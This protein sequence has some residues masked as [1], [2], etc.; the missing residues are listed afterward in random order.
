[1][2]QQQL[3]NKFTYPMWGVGYRMNQENMMIMQRRRNWKDSFES[4]FIRQILPQNTHTLITVMPI[5]RITTLTPLHPHS[6]YPH[7]IT[8]HQQLT[9]LPLLPNPP[10]TP[11][12]SQPPLDTTL[13]TRSNSRIG[14]NTLPLYTPRHRLL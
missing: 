10:R 11:P 4:L 12:S 7:L 9:P 8:T 6:P 5:L 1:M 3:Q 14:K 2:R 13:Y